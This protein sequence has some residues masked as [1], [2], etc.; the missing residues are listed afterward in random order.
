MTKEEINYMMKN[1]F[2]I[3]EIMEMEK[4][5]ENL[6]KEDVKE[7][8]KE[9]ASIPV[10]SE[11]ATTDE[12]GVDKKKVSS[13]SSED[14]LNHIKHLEETIKTLQDSNRQN[15]TIEAPEEYTAE[16]AIKD[17]FEEVK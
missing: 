13:N 7:D 4:P 16:Q 12:A 8:A 9:D 1:G 11:K 3:S 5:L 15:V 10:E 6:T 14:I 17:L 2:S